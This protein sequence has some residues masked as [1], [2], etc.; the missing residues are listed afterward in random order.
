MAR[1][2]QPIMKKCKALGIMPADLG[3][4]EKKSNRQPKISR[5]KPSEYAIQLKEKQK[6]KFMYGL[7]EKQ[8]RAYYDKADRMKGIT[9][10][11]MLFMLEKRLDNIIFR[12]GIGRSRAHARQIVSHGHITINGNPVNIPSYQTKLNDVI[13]VRD[14]K[15]DS[16]M[17]KELKGAKI[18]MP[19]WVEFDTESLTGKII[20]KPEREDIDAN[21]N[22][23][24]I[25]ELYSK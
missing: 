2:R 14:T 5:K 25:V 13:A 12:M 11:N 18:V 17:F 16:E 9:G 15:K 20:A 24:L 6:V 3:Y 1:N 21:I 22:E 8:F 19:K 23:Q 4:S 10:E 7:L